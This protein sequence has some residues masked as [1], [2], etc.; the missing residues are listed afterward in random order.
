MSIPD[1]LKKNWWVSSDGEVL[2]TEDLANEFED[3]DTKRR[4]IITKKKKEIQTYKDFSEA[5]RYSLVIKYEKKREEWDLHAE[6]CLRL[7]AEMG[8]IKMDMHKLE[9]IKKSN[10]KEQNGESDEEY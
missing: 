8:S 9:E 7:N 6:C 2:R 10:K 3:W 1:A 4:I 5:A